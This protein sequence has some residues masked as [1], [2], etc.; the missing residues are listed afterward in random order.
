MVQIPRK[1]AIVSCHEHGC[2][3]HPCANAHGR[4]EHLTFSAP[5]LELGKPRHDLA[6]ATAAERVAERAAIKG[7]SPGVSVT[8]ITHIAPPLTFTRLMSR[9]SWLTQ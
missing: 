3:T 6:D 9:P 8:S 1:E 2:P 5:L 4:Y 7:Q